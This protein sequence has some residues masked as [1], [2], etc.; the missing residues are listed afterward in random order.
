MLWSFEIF[1]FVLVQMRK[2]LFVISFKMIV[3]L[4][5]TKYANDS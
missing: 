3:F 5:E 2:W 1:G 4:G